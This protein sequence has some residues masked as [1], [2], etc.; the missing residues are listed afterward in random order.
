MSYDLAGWYEEQKSIIKQIF[1]ID[2]QVKEQQ[3][4]TDNN[5]IPATLL[6]EYYKRLLKTFF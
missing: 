6:S 3:Q 4:P 1:K 5:S 2:S